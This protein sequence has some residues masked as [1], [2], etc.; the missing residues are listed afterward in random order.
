MDDA[1]FAP[2]AFEFPRGPIVEVFWIDSASGHGWSH[3]EAELSNE[4]RYKSMC[5]RTVG[6]VIFEDDLVIEL[7]SGITGGDYVDCT[8][9]IP[10]A[11]IVDRRTLAEG[12]E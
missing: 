10:K 7:V 11:A 12:R 5:C 1:R 9:M 2:A 4:T 8:E 6:F 3:R